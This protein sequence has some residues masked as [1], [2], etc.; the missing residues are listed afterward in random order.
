MTHPDSQETSQREYLRALAWGARNA[1]K[2]GV[3]WANLPA[4]VQWVAQR[5]TRDQFRPMQPDEVERYAAVAVK[6]FNAQQ[7]R[8][9][10][11]PKAAA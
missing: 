7:E 9:E 10:W 3:V 2:E 8:R 1:R 4:C 5:F 11:A 6:L